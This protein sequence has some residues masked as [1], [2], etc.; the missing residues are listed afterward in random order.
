[1]RTVDARL[2]EV[3]AGLRFL[4][5]VA[6]LQHCAEPAL[7]GSKKTI[8]ALM[9]ATGVKVNSAGDQSPKQKDEIVSH[10][11][12]LGGDRSVS[13]DRDPAPFVFQKAD[14]AWDMFFNEA[15]RRPTDA[16][17]SLLRD[18]HCGRGKA[19]PA[20]RVGL[21]GSGPSHFSPPVLPQAALDTWDDE[22][23]S[24]P[25]NGERNVPESMR[26][27][28]GREEFFDDAIDSEVVQVVVPL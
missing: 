14:A 10:R 3:I 23:V 20:R 16:T 9:E 13:L 11:L 17:S 1:M 2:A 27:R 19:E 6:L 15:R 7:L 18:L 8:T 5:C 22:L 24:I 26:M 4:A 12:G 28:S 21:P 25:G